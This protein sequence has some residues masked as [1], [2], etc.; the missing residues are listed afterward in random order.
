M[1]QSYFEAYV[2]LWRRIVKRG[3][4]VHYGMHFDGSAG[5]FQHD[6]QGG[7]H[8]PEISIHR[9]PVPADEEEPSPTLDDGTPVDVEADLITLAHEFA[10]FLSWKE[11]TSAEVWAAYH[12][13]V[14]R[15]AIEID[16]LSDVPAAE[17][18]EAYRR[19]WS[20]LSADEKALV[21]DE[22]TTAWRLGRPHVPEAL[23]PTYDARTVKGLLNY[24]YRLG[25]DSACPD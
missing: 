20:A 3:V 12:R 22:E 23:L 11:V 17:Y 25:L 24:R 5:W 16:A 6:G 10:H 15:L 4:W 9:V 21:L 19:V 18:N 1:P 8:L 13:V 14:D 2:H 7:Y